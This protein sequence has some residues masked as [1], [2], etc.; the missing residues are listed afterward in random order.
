MRGLQVFSCDDGPSRPLGIPEPD[1]VHAI[2]HNTSATANQ[3]KGASYV[4]F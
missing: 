2:L 1:M 3:A 4:C